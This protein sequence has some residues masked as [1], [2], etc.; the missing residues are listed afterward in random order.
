MHIYP[1]PGP[2]SIMAGCHLTAHFNDLRFDIPQST[3]ANS[4]AQK[5][6]NCEG[7]TDPK[8]SPVI[9]IFFGR[10]SDS[11]IGVDVCLCL[12]LTRVAGFIL[13]GNI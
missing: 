6:Y 11:Y 5:A 7:N 13:C 8:S 3:N 1:N 12:V 9:A 2:Q 10:R 4:N